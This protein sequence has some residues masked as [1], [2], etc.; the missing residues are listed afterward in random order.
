MQG[1]I[2]GLFHITNASNLKSIMTTGLQPGHK[3]PRALKAGW[4][5]LHFTAFSDFEDERGPGRLDEMTAR[6][7]QA[8]NE[9][10]NDELAAKRYLREAQRSPLTQMDV[11]IWK[12]LPCRR[13]PSRLLSNP[14][15]CAEC[16]T[17]GVVYGTKIPKEVIQEK[18]SAEVPE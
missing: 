7:T 6:L 12:G 13:C 9:I 18:S 5:D 1:S 16:L 11:E 10:D 15:G 2:S 4:I 17:C 8:R 14:A 3:T